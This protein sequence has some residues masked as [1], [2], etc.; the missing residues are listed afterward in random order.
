MSP[1]LKSVIVAGAVLACRPTSGLMMLDEAAEA[2]GELAFK[3]ALGAGAAASEALFSRRYR[4]Q[5]K[6][7]LGTRGDADVCDAMKKCDPTTHLCTAEVKN[8]KPEVDFKLQV[9]EHDRYISRMALCQ[10]ET[11][12]YGNVKD[13]LDGLKDR[14]GWN[15]LD[16]GANIGSWALPTAMAMKG[17]TGT[18]LAVEADPQTIGAL[19]ES[20]SMNGVKDK[21]SLIQGAVVRDQKANPEICLTMG[22]AAESGNVGENQANLGEREGKADCNKVVKTLSLDSLYERDP[23]MKHM[24]AAKLDCEGC[25]GQAIM[26]A[27]KFL[28]ES[29]PCFLAFEATE[30]YLCE[31]KTP[32]PE[33]K[34]FLEKHG[35]DTKDIV[36]HGG[37]TCD[38]YNEWEKVHDVSQSFYTLQRHDMKACMDRFEQ[39][40]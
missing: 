5:L 25:E 7:S 13:M 24:I 35:Y 28:S 11:W 36:V 32:L 40:L 20:V 22:D 2:E 30:R 33:L 8:G 16:V 9:F 1:P 27:S 6:T 4:A 38:E 26:G 31:A 37:A 18:L 14:K 23:A 3:S 21:V 17:Q 29:P 19:A 12:E 39:V 15:F 34:E 10:Q